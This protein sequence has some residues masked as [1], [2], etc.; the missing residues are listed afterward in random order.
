MRTSLPTKATNVRP[1]SKQ[2]KNALDFWIGATDQL[3]KT[4]RSVLDLFR[5]NKDLKNYTKYE[6]QLGNFKS[7]RNAL[8]K[9]VDKAIQSNNMKHME[10]VIADAVKKLKANI[11]LHVA[12][13]K[14]YQLKSSMSKEYDEALVALTKCMAQLRKKLQI[15]GRFRNK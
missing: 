7:M 3:E 5:R 15:V 10:T 4:S 9:D 6:S 1:L 8:T 2:Q 13:P 14:K 11:Y 12:P